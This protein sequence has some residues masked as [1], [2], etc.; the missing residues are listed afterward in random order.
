[1][2]SASKPLK[3]QVILGSTRD[4]RYGDKPARWIADEF[5]KQPGVA[6]ELLDLRDWP[7]PFFN[8]AIPPAAGKRANVAANAWGAK[9]AE[10]DAY[11]IV[12]P[13]YNR[14]YPA[15]LKNAL[16]WVYTEVN[17]KPVTFLSYGGAGGAR[18]VEQ[19]RQVANE[20]KMAPIRTGIHLPLESYLA[21]MKLTAPVDPALYNDNQRLKGQADAAITELLWWAN[22]L[23]TARNQ[24]ALGKAA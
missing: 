9:L 19:L 2:T 21:T 1:M 17:Q 23:R 5:A 15:V 18:A 10:A 24:V 11:V 7:L 16:D 6:V 14:G 20:L 22:A 3:I 13:E 8:E 12:T 4:G